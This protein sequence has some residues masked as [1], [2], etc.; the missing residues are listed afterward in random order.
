MADRVFIFHET[1]DRFRAFEFDGDAQVS[2]NWL[3]N[4]TIVKGAAANYTHIYVLDLSVNPAIARKY[5]IGKVRESAGDITMSKNGSYE[6]IALTPTHLVAIRQQGLE[7]Y[8]LSDGMYD[9][10]MD[11]SLP[12]PNTSDE[13]Y[14]S[15]CRSGDFFISRNGRHK[16][17]PHPPAFI[18]GTSMDLPLA[19]GREC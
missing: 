16:W 1:D 2:E 9:S 4:L 8:Q 5:T 19:I 13:Y 6:G 15:I 18:N 3:P 17:S 7:Y 11:V 10:S 14:S 12:A